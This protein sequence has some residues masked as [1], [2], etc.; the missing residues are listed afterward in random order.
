MFLTKRQ[1]KGFGILFFIW[2][3]GSLIVWLMVPLIIKNGVN[4]NYNNDP[5]SV[6]S[7]GYKMTTTDRDNY[8]KGADNLRWITLGLGGFLWFLSSF[9]I[10]S[11]KIKERREANE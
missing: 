6:A 10:V 4:N 7:T 11:W 1:H 8:L 9:N 2:G 3:L 5:E